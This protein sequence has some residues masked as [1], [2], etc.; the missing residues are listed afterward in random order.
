MGALYYQNQIARKQVDHLRG[1][2][3]GTGYALEIGNEYIATIFNCYKDLVKHFKKHG[4]MKKVYDTTRE[5]EHAVRASFHMIPAD[6]LDAF[7]SLFEEARYSD[8]TIG[9][10]QRDRA[11]ATLKAIST[12]LTMALGEEGT[13]ERKTVV[14]LYE[15]TTKAGEFK[16]ADGTVI[17]AGQTEGEDSGF[18][19]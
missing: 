15:Q 6:Q 12:S 4:Y 18:S 9:A 16:T 13:V 11:I 14:G 5:F 3:H 2:I 1:L 17:Q 8:H 19:I 7:L 10:D